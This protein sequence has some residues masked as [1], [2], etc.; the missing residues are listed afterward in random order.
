METIISNPA[1]AVLKVVLVR[2]ISG[3]GI[4]SQLR[5]NNYHR[6]SSA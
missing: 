1:K 3:S 2:G 6:F 4:L 5:V